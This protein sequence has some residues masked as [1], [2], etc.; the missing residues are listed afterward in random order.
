M[1]PTLFYSEDIANWLPIKSSFKKGKLAENYNDDLDQIIN[2]YLL[3]NDSEDINPFILPISLNGIF[4]DFSGLIFAHHIRL[5]RNIKCCD[6]TIVLYGTLEVEQLLRLTPLAR[7]LLTDNVLYFNISNFSFEEIIKSAQEHYTIFDFI[8]FIKQIQIDPPSNYEGNHHSAD[9]E[10]ALIQWSK[11]IGCYNILPNEFKKEFDSRLFLKYLRA[12]NTVIEGYTKNQISISTD[13]SVNVLLI[14]D[15]AR[16]GW[17]EFYSSLFSNSSKKIKFEDSNIDFKVPNISDVIN[18]LVESKVIQFKPDIVLLDLRLLDS[19]FDN[20]TS[21]SELTGLKILEKI[22]EINKGIQV[23]ITTASNKA[24][25]FNLAKQKGAYDFIIKDGLEDPKIAITKL[26]QTIENA[27]KRSLYLKPIY[28]KTTISLNAWNNYH[29]PQR[30]NISDPM[31]DTL[32]HINLKL[33]V[34]DFIKN[35][36]DTINNDSIIE[37]FTISTLLLYRVIEMINEFYIIESGD[38]WNNT[39]Q[40]HFDLDNTKI[41]KIIYTNNAYSVSTRV[42]IGSNFSTKEKSYAVYHKINGITNKGLFNKIHQLTEYRNKVTIH[43]NKRF[44]EESLEYIFDTD[45]NRFNHIL[46]EY[47]SAILDYVSSFK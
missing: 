32:W 37:R 8:R 35:A 47:F 12:K 20:D 21:P 2:T 27:C 18:S 17:K 10:F 3:E 26:C 34:I 33:Q 40:Y 19:D 16:K 23:I 43:P 39:N 36:F 14:D 28:E 42:H 38:Y 1:T 31:H 9:N 4:F 13:G 6:T 30:V 24:W 25:N 46:N 7:I 5:T 11:Y 45:F 15:E 29:V 41:P 22:K 44:K